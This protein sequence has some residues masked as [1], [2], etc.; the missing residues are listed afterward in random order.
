[1]FEFLVANL[2]RGKSGKVEISAHVRRVL[3]DHGVSVNHP[4]EAIKA[5]WRLERGTLVG[6]AT[7][8]AERAVQLRGQL[9]DA[10][11]AHKQNVV[12]RKVGGLGKPRAGAVAD[13]LTTLDMVGAESRRRH[14]ERASQLLVEAM[15]NLMKQRFGSRGLGL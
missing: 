7:R 11:H 10:F 2:G 1:M 9:R 4:L 3:D 8:P 6:V 15:Q 5:A 12:L 14:N 13:I